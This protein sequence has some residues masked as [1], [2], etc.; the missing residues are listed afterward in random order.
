MSTKAATVKRATEPI[1]FKMEN[2]MTYEEIA[3]GLLEIHAELKR[4]EVNS[5]MDLYSKGEIYALGLLEKHG[6]CAYPKDLS[7]IMLVSSARIAVILNHM[8]AKGWILRSTD[9]KDTRQ[10]IVSL[11]DTGKEVYLEQQREMVSSLASA[12][13]KLGKEDAEAMLR[14]RKKMLKNYKDE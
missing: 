1:I 11:T 13:E 2:A 5:Q 7:R 3:E 6:G 14:I 9:A 12:L 8:E 10:T 4:L